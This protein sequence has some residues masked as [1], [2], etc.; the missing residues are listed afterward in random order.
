MVPLLFTCIVL[1]LDTVMG[2]PIIYDPTVILEQLEHTMLAYELH[3]IAQKS[4]RRTTQSLTTTMFHSE[5]LY[6]L[7]T[8]TKNKK[9]D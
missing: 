7:Q 9:L 2:E 8:A 6:S 5:V 1:P 3:S 4:K